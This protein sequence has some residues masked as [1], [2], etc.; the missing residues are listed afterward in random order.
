M[1]A[2]GKVVLLLLWTLLLLPAQVAALGLRSSMAKRI[3]VLYHRVN[4]RIVGITVAVAGTPSPVAPTLIV[5]NHTSYLDIIVLSALKPVSFV[6]KHEVASW[7]LFGLLAKLQ[8]SVFVVRRAARSAAHRDEI[9]ERLAGGDDLVLF[10]EGTSNDGNRVLRFNST[11]FAVA[12]QDIEGKPLT[13][14]P[15]SI[16]YNAL[17]NL[18]MRR[19]MRPFFAWYGDMDLPSHLWAALT[20]A[21]FGVTVVFHPP[22][23]RE[24][25]GSRKA[26]AL[27]CHRV[28][29]DGVA[30]ALTGREAAPAELQG[31]A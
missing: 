6:A 17:G 9:A 7:P 12:D 29:A 13:V 8:R 28:V 15:V 1:K 19:S 14:Q 2:A 24:S 25:F 16:A 21:P 30:A 27:H 26:M 11:F 23:T 20:M 5:A 22:I 3:P 31:A 18:P 4:C 10:P